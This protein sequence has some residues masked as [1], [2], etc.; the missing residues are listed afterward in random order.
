MTIVTREP[1]VFSGFHRGVAYKLNTYG[2]PDP[3]GTDPYIGPY[4]GLEIFAAKT[5]NMTVPGTRKVS[6]IG[7]DRLIAVQQFPSQEPITGEIG[8]GAE[9]LDLVAL[10][11][12]G[13]II[14]KAEIRL[15]PHGSDLQ[16]NEP[17]VGFIMVQDALAQ[18]GPQRSHVLIVPST[19]AVPRVPGAGAEPIDY[20]YDLAPNPVNQHLWGEGL[21]LLSDPSDPYSGISESGAEY[22]SLWSGMSEYEPR[23]C[24]WLGQAG[25]VEFLF[26]EDKQAADTDKV[27]IWV[28]IGSTVTEIT[29]AITI[30]TTGVTFDTAPVT[31]YGAGVEVHVLYQL[32]E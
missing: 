16:G 30:A 20:I 10:M 22:A 26:P 15:L 6:H 18:S 13:D 32:A 11:G 1:I 31:T 5:F 8:V 12:G 25:Q 7:N 27:E 19:K 3:S 29:S 17:N 4:T 21:S 23:L 14:T 2:R 28:A 24:S 9:D